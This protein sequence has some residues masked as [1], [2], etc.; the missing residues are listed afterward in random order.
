MSGSDGGADRSDGNGGDATVREPP[1]DTGYDEWVDALAA[2]EGFYVECAN[3]HGSLPPRRVC[4][5]CGSRDLSEE[6]LPASG[7]LATFSEVH[8]A[9]PAFAD[10]TPYVTGIADFGPVRITGAVRGVDADAV[11]VGT[12]VS[13]GVADRSDDAAA[14]RLVV[15]EPVDAGEA[16]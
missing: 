13:V 15:L 14:E 2:G 16:A 5:E 6:P 10:E 1:R 9:P 8:V 3:G 12:R 4:P 7:E 11:A